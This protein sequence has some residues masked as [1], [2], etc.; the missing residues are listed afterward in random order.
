MSKKNI[1]LEKKRSIFFQTGLIVSLA[2]V[3]FAFEWT[4]TSYDTYSNNAPIEEGIDIEKIIQ[5]KVIKPQA[6]QVTKVVKKTNYIKVVKEIIKTEVKEKPI[7]TKKTDT[8]DLPVITD[9]DMSEPEV[10]EPDTIAASLVEIQ[11]YFEE[12]YNVL[13]RDQQQD[14]SYAKIIGHIQSNFKI[15]YMLQDI[16]GKTYVSF[17]VNKKGIVEDVKILKGVHPRMNKEAIRVVESIPR[18]IPASQQGK[19]VAVKYQIPINVNVQ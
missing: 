18:M 5:I 15:P 12:C 19:A 10:I 9:V 7:I 16:G 11:P 6:E 17:I 13:D 2:F 8:K 3:L 4:S 14:C 1:S